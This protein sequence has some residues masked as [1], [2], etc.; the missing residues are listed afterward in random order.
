MLLASQTFSGRRNC[1]IPNTRKNKSEVWGELIRPPITLRP[2][3]RRGLE[4]ASICCRPSSTLGSWKGDRQVCGEQTLQSQ[5][6]VKKTEET[7]SSPDHLP[8]PGD[9]GVNCFSLPFEF[10][11]CL[12][13]PLFSSWGCDYHVGPFLFHPATP[14]TLFLWNHSSVYFSIPATGP[15]GR[16]RGTDGTAHIPTPGVDCEANPHSSHPRSATLR[17]WLKS[18]AWKVS[19]LAWEASTAPG[20]T[21][22]FLG[23]VNVSWC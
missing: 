2:V 9:A 11:I 15:E 21:P 3:R 5:T 16:T 18:G 10:F 22:G 13:V 12:F 19:G 7:D 20:N 17:S 1:S 6:R 4:A 23:C 14:P 8:T